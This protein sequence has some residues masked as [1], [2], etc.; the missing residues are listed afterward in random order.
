M[1]RGGIVALAV[2]A[3]LACVGLDNHLRGAEQDSPAG[4]SP[5]L[6]GAPDVLF[7]LSV[8]E[9]R[10]AVAALEKR[11]GQNREA[12]AL[13][14][15]CDKPE[16]LP[17]VAEK[18]QQDIADQKSGQDNLMAI[19]QKIQ[20]GLRE[21]Q[22]LRARKDDLEKSIADEKKGIAKAKAV[23][24]AE[25]TSGKE[26]SAKSKG[27]K[28]AESGS[29]STGTSKE[30]KEAAKQEAKTLAEQIEIDRRELDRLGPQIQAAEKILAEARSELL[31]EVTR[32]D[33]AGLTWLAKALIAENTEFLALLRKIGGAGGTLKTEL[34][35][36]SV[37]G[38]TQS[39]RG[40]L[41][42]GADIDCS[43]GDYSALAYAKVLGLKEIGSMLV[44]NGGV[45]QVPWDP[46]RDEPIRTS[47]EMMDKQLD[48]LRAFSTTLG[49]AATM[50][51]T[52]YDILLLEWVTCRFEACKAAVR[53]HPDLA[54][55]KPTK[56]RK[57]SEITMKG[58]E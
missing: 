32:A 31:G 15:K 3:I 17:E 58:Q 44:K 34:V 54:G 47:V 22:R 21:L 55:H 38:R 46:N 1:K 37:A 50:A 41:E 29:A 28:G 40:M 33:E 56:Q 20:E 57:A 42:S 43:P 7:S 16:P 4:L 53:N 27:G 25:V 12:S 35:K 13:A 23:A 14:S 45:V 24:N 8:A 39:V 6:P 11:I 26:E 36:A 10:E 49:N 18:I 51:R 2:V 48:R 30:D 19:N 52:T 9:A 5:S